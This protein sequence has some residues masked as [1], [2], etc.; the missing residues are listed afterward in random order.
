MKIDVVASGK[1]IR[2]ATR[3]GNDAD[4]AVAGVFIPATM[5]RLIDESIIA[6]KNFQQLDSQRPDAEGL[7]DARSSSP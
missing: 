3:V 1:W 7:A 5:S 4:V 2:T 6:H